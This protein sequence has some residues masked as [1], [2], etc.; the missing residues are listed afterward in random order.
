MLTPPI[1]LPYADRL[2]AMLLCEY[3]RCNV[4]LVVLMGCLQSQ[5]QLGSSDTKPDFNYHRQ[6]ERV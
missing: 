4:L 2:H 5:F 1:L 6:V 3:F